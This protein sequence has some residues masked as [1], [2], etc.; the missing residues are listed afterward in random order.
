MIEIYDIIIIITIIAALIYMVITR[1]N[2]VVIITTL[3][4]AGRKIIIFAAIRWY[5][6][7]SYVS[8][9]RKRYNYYG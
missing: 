2:R 8:G 5:S 9:T 4:V 6:W 3:G 1:L 7:I